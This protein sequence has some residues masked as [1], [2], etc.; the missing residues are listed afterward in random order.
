L[1][2]G[3]NIGIVTAIP[4]SSPRG[5]IIVARKKVRIIFVGGFLGAGKTTLLWN[6]ARILIARGK[7]VGLITNDQ[8]PDL[9]DTGLLARRGLCVAEVAGSCFCCNFKGLIRA[10]G[11]MRNETR[12]DVLLAEP[13]GSC[14]DLSAT[15]LQPLKERF[16]EEFIPTP[17]SVLADPERTSRV[18]DGKRLGMHRSTA[19]IIRKQ[20]EEADRILVSKADL[21]REA[22]RGKLVKKISVAF[23][24]TPV[25]TISSLTGEGVADWLDDVFSSGKAG[26]RIADIDY[27]TYAEGEAVLGWLNAEIALDANKCC[28]PDWRLLGLFLMQRFRD[29]CRERNTPVGHVKMLLTTGDRTCAVNL[30]RLK[31]KIDLRGDV[32]E[33]KPKARL[34]V[35]ARVEMP[36][37]DLE[38]LLKENLELLLKGRVK[39]GYRRLQCFR[40]GRPVPTYRHREVVLP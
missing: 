25:R 9:V 11:K 14:T 38:H 29:A 31:G 1:E 23:P 16:R 18:L 34:V 26:S 2:T 5:A 40:P 4:N 36:P 27:D 3:S 15:I 12:A 37:E 21:L 19:Y 28:V 10:A 6:A 32:D 24:D 35:N 30:T 17:L 13:V 22:R 7:R 39:I 20:F 33:S 8:A